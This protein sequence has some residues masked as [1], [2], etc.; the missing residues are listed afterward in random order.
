MGC[1]RKR[2]EENPTRGGDMLKLKMEG[3]TPDDMVAAIAK[4]HPEVTERLERARTRV[5]FLKREVWLEQAAVIYA[6]AS[7]YNFEGAHI[8]E[9][10]TAWGY[11]AA[12]M[13]EAAPLANIITLN[14]KHSEMHYA[15]Q[16]LADYANVKP[17]EVTSWEYY[18]TY[19]GPFLDMIFVDGNHQLCYRD[20]PWWSWINPDGLMLWH[21]YSPEDASK[22]PCIW[23][24]E[25]LNAMRAGMKD[26]DVLAISDVKV[27][28]AGWYKLKKDMREAYECPLPASTL[29]QW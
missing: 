6:L 5:P 7:Q 26:F 17:I 22:R 15:E 16:H 24:Y 1:P 11:S 25:F 18:R 27:G 20:F 29:T 23:V 13:A 8:L 14:P 4:M 9:V 3:M 21:D 19:A 10:G 28:M 2:I 12:V